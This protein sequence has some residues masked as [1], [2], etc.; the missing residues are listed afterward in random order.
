[1][2]HHPEGYFINLGQS[3]LSKFKPAHDLGVSVGVKGL[4]R[5]GSMVWPG[6]LG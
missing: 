2:K 6:R 3:K 5:S 4:G 1:M